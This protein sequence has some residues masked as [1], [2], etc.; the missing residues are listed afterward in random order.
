MISKLLA[1]IFL[2]IPSISVEMLVELLKQDKLQL[3]DVRT[4]KEYQG[5]HI[6]QATNTPL[7]GLAQFRGDK[8]EPLYVICQSGMRSKRACRFLANQGYQVV[9]VKG[10]MSH[11]T[12]KTLLVKKK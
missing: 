5:G 1:C 8:Q 2:R 6:R 7:S 10:G 11:W 3:V 12:D 9:D 4:R